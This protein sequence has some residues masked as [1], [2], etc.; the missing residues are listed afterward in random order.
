MRFVETSQSPE[1][2]TRNTGSDGDLA[3]YLSLELI[4]AVAKRY[5][6]EMAWRENIRQYEAI[7]PSVKGRSRPYAEN[8]LMEVPLGATRSDELESQIDDLIF[9][10]SEVYIARGSA[11]Y[12]K[13]A[14]A[15]QLL[16]NKFVEDRFTN[17]RVA[18]DAVIADTV[19][20]GTGTYYNV[21]SEEVVRSGAVN[22]INRGPR[23]YSVPTEDIIV[24][25]GAYSDADYLRF[26][27]YRMYLNA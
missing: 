15:C 12:D 17:L 24:P 20:L 7:P 19:Q 27:S 21:R 8:F 11:G 25:G 1:K 14:Y 5:W 26:V 4:D 18:A 16:A 22:I 3:K 23:V 13:A 6:Q 10:Q 2:F 9:N